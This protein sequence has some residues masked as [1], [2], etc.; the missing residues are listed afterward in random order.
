MRF[1]NLFHKFTL[2]AACVMLSTAPAL[3][4]NTGSLVPRQQRLLNGLTLLMWSDPAGSA[5]RVSVRIHSGSSVDPQGTEGGM[6]LLGDN[7]F[8]AAASRGYF[9]A[10]LGGSVEVITKYDYI[11]VNASAKPDQ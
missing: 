8:P 5:V 11:Q 4:Q 10:D 2:L 3:S 6:Q 1:R 9:S 7:T